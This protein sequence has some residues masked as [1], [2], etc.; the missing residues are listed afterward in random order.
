MNNPKGRHKKD[1]TERAVIIE[2][3]CK[4]AHKRIDGKFSKEHDA[5]EYSRNGSNLKGVGYG[6][7]Y[8]SI[9]DAL[10]FSTCFDYFRGK[11]SKA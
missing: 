7:L 11:S 1:I 5:Q 2:Q 4:T 6:H 3:S 10:I 8:F 9:E